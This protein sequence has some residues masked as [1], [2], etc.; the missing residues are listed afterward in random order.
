MAYKMTLSSF[1]GKTFVKQVDNFWLILPLLPWEVETDSRMKKT[2]GKENKY[3]L[4]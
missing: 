3:F 2:R 1:A 4:D